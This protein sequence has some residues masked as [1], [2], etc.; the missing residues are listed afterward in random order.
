MARYSKP[1]FL[2]VARVLRAEY[3]QAGTGLV[4]AGVFRAAEAMANI[5]QEDN[6]L[7]DRQ[8]FLDIVQWRR[9]VAAPR[10]E[11]VL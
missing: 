11:E 9:P 10:P 5:F 4:Q 8:H 2:N 6:R 1:D 7:F 3:G